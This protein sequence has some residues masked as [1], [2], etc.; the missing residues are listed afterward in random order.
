[1]KKITLLTLLCALAFSFKA[2]AQVKYQGEVEVGY[3]LGIGELDADRVNF[4]VINSARIGDYF[5]A[6]IGIGLDLY[7]EGDDNELALPV[8]VNLKGYLPLTSVTQLFV[9]MNTGV[10]IGV[11]SGL[12]SNRGLLLNPSVG[13]RFKV[14]NRNAVSVGVGYVNQFWSKSGVALITDAVQ[15]KVGFSF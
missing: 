1:M 7:T 5:S 13:A 8:Y 4:H 2:Q 10:S 15:V 9:S 3:S 6:G 11:S 14:S 12:S